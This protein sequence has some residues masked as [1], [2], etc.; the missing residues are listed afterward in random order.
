[1]NFEEGQVTKSNGKVINSESEEHRSFQFEEYIPKFKIIGVG[2]AGNNLTEKLLDYGIPESRLVNVYLN[3]VSNISSRIKG[4]IT[5]CKHSMR[6][7]SW[8]G[9]PDVPKECAIESE[10]NLKNGISDCNTILIMAGL[11]HSIGTGASPELARIFKEMNP[12]NKVISFVTLPF[13]AEGQAFMNYAIEGFENIKKYSDLITVIPNN[14]VLKLYRRYPLDQI[15]QVCDKI[16]AIAVAALYDSI[17]QNSDILNFIDSMKSNKKAGISMLAFG[18]S[19]DS[20]EDA[21]N[22]ALKNPLNGIDM[23]EAIGMMALL[24]YRD[25]IEEREMKSTLN[26]I[27]KKLNPSAF[28]SF[29]SIR[30]ERI[31]NKIRMVLLP[32]ALCDGQT[33]DRKRL[34]MEI[35]G[36]ISQSVQDMVDSM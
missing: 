20:T 4:S 15:F 25:N 16:D 31:E 11:G 28:L 12:G 3:G 24:Y 19:D 2:H 18:N 21:L 8:C 34:E 36:E 27:R 26:K 1:M 30:D 7:L 22:K 6:G 32:V 29:N 35:T 17:K 5:I 9:N 10:D 14:R 33:F 13:G 23:R